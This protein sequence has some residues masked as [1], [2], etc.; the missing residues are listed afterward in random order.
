MRVKEIKIII[1]VDNENIGF[2]V[3]REKGAAAGVPETLELVS[4]LELLKKN[5]LDKIEQKFRDVK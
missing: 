4:Y 5:Q 3:N 2:A 1:R